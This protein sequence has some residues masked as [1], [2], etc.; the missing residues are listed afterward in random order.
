MLKGTQIFYVPTSA[1]GSLIHPNVEA[2]F[3]MKE[4]MNGTAHFCRF[5][6]SD[7][8]TLRTRSVSE[9]TL[10]L[11]L[12]EKDSVPQEQVL[13]AIAQIAEEI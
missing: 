6:N 5:W 3:V 13:S 12:V 1:N 10:T 11:F 8:K 4:V 2:G 7:K 9:L